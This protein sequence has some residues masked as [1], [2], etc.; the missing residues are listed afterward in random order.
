MEH[1]GKR[2]IVCVDI[3][4]DFVEGGS[5]AVAG[6]Q[7]VADSLGLVLPFFEESGVHVF[8]TKDWHIDPGDHFSENPDF[9][10]SWPRHCEANTDGAE[11]AAPFNVQEGHLFLK[12][13]YSASYSGAEGKNEFGEDLISR[14]HAGN[15]DEVTVVGIAFDYCVAATASDIAVAGLYVNI[16]KVVTA[17]VH[18]ENDDA[19]I[20]ELTNRGVEVV[21]P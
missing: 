17:S 7:E 5:L 8:Y 12:G 19:T 16:A 10:S 11:F 20:R 21:L 2:A 4:K 1:T 13:Q 18:P 6:G 3:Q 14:L 9:S 15:Y